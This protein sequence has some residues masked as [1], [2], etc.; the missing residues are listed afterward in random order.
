MNNSNAPDLKYEKA[1][2]VIPSDRNVQNPKKRKIAAK[3]KKTIVPITQI[4]FSLLRDIIISAAT[5]RS[6]LPMVVLHFITKSL[7]Y[8]ILIPLIFRPRKNIKSG[9]SVHSAILIRDSY[10]G[11]LIN[12]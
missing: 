11:S 7:L 12:R 1:I 3:H 5:M 4:V 9:E 6:S 8:G 10:A 2:G